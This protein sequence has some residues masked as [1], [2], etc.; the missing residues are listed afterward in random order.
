MIQD[1]LLIGELADRLIVLDQGE[2]IAE[3]SS[4]EVLENPKVLR[5]FGG[6]TNFEMHKKDG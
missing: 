2:K 5:I 4:E 3:G 1:I 6:M